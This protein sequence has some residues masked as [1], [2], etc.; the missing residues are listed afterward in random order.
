MLHH[1]SE[2][3]NDISYS[4]FHRTRLRLRQFILKAHE[5]KR[6][7]DALSEAI[8]SLR[9]SKA[10]YQQETGHGLTGDMVRFDYP[11]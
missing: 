3:D 4:E 1:L 7:D 9:Y 10:F 5:D 11:W 8:V 2:F 6:F